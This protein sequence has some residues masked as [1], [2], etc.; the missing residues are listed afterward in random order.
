MKDSSGEY[1]L[2]DQE[3]EGVSSTVC[4]KIGFTIMSDSLQKEEKL[5]HYHDIYY[6]NEIIK[7]LRQLSVKR[8]STKI[9]RMKQLVLSIQDI[10][11]Y[12]QILS[13]CFQMGIDLSNTYTTILSICSMQIHNLKDDE[14]PS[15]QKEMILRQLDYYSTVV[16]WF[17]RLLEKYSSRKDSSFYVSNQT[18]LSSSCEILQYAKLYEDQ[19]LLS[20]SPTNTTSFSYQ[21]LPIFIQ[22]IQSVVVYSFLFIRR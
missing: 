17:Y 19:F 2:Y 5:H 20:P 22:S 11:I 6:K 10:S 16:S 7:L 3:E 13:D 18:N 8:D 9:E 14:T 4:S 21:D 1:I 15:E 12:V